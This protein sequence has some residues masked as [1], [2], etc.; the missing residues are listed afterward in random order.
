MRSADEILR[1]SAKDVSHAQGVSA[2]DIKV[3]VL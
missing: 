2:A 1:I 3:Q